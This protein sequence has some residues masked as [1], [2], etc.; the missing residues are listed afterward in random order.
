MVDIIELQKA[1]VKR[2]ISR[3]GLIREYLLRN[4]FNDTSGF[5]NNGVGNNVFF[6]D[7]QAQFNGINSFVTIPNINF[8]VGYSISLRL[9]LKNIT[10]TSYFIG[11][12]NIGIRYNGISFLALYSVSAASSELVYNKIEDDINLIIYR[13]TNTVTSIYIDN[14]LLGDLTT[15]NGLGIFNLIGSRSDAFHFNGSICRVRF[16]NREL[17]SNEKKNLKNEY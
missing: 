17:S 8:N 14:I 1:A 5:N 2:K 11:G 3:D 9:N 15:D 12:S 13:K 6:I 10:N 16:Y 4:D 7:G